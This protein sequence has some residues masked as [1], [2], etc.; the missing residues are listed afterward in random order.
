MV[1]QITLLHLGTAGDHSDFD[2]QTIF[3]FGIL[4]HRLSFYL[5]F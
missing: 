4:I 3:L 5:G 2:L 1:T